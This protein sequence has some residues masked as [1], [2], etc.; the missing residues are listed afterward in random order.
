MLWNTLCCPRQLVGTDFG[1][2][3]HAFFVI[4]ISSKNIH[5]L[6]FKNDEILSIFKIILKGILKFEI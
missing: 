3:I 4:I 6:I 1:K 2:G 5:I